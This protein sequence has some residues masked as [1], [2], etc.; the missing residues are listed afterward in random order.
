MYLVHCAKADVNFARF[1][2]YLESEIMHF[3]ENRPQNP[4]GKCR[5]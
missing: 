1:Y 3:L 4:V 5:F 2:P